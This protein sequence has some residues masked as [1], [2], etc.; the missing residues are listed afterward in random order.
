M[1]CLIAVAAAT[2][3]ALEAAVKRLTPVCTQDNCGTAHS[4]D[5]KAQHMRNAVHGV[6]HG[7]YALPVAMPVAR[8]LQ[9]HV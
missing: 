9:P 3:A 2:S 4:M 6:E 8:K 1:V 7:K 5:C